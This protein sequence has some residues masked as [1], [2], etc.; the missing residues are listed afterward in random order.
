MAAL[1]AGLRVINVP[2]TSVKMMKELPPVYAVVHD[3]KEG[4]EV[5]R[6]IL[7]SGD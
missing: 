2:D 5:V 3:F 7:E 6:R 1:N 4:M